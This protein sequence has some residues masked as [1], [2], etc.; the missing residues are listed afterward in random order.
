MQL[1]IQSFTIGFAIIGLYVAFNWDGMLL[2]PIADYLDIYLDNKYG[3]Y[4]RKPLYGCPT[5]MS[6]IWSIVY[7]LFL[8]VNLDWTILLLILIVAGISTTISTFLNW[9]TNE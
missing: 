6:S 7:C 2:K 8:R 1:L 4:L 3:K 9:L 5:C